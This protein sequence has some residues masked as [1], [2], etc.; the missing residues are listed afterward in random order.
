ML[1][2]SLGYMLGTTQQP[3]LPTANTGG[4]M[5]DQ[6]PDDDMHMSLVYYLRRPAIL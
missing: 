1:P 6:I 4:S 3:V 5:T 2:G